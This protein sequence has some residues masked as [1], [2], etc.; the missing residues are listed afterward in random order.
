MIDDLL[1]AHADA[2]VRDAEQPRSGID[3]HANAELGIV[4]EQLGAGEALETEPVVGIGSVGDQLAEENLS[5]AVERMHH[6]V[7]QLLDLG[8][9]RESGRPVFSIGA[10]CDSWD[11]G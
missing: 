3:G 2:V 7:Q 11:G 6:E 8:L 9:K 10:P 4:R 1:A 5:L